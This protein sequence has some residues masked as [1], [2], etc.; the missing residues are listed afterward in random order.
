MTLRALCGIAAAVLLAAC[1]AEPPPPAVTRP[2]R[3][4]QVV[5]AAALTGRF[6]PGRAQATQE[7]NLGFR[8]SGPLITRPVNV[9]DE[10]EKGTVL[11]Q[12]DR[13]DFEVNLRTV[14]AQLEESRGRGGACR[15]GA[16]A[17]SDRVRPQRR[18]RDRAH[19]SSPGG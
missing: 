3:A 12:I 1:S 16:A 10:V 4:I 19:S 14:E 17:R 9:G 7:V 8:V 5:D 15:R 6:L 13:R 18:L 2:V 11:A